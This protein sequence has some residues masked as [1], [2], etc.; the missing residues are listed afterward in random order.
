MKKEIKLPRSPKEPR[1]HSLM[2]R[3]FRHMH[4][5]DISSSGG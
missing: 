1:V 3:V 2:V 4:A 5:I